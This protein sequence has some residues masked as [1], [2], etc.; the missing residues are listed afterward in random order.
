[1]CVYLPGVL[2]KGSL[3]GALKL[4]L[5]ENFLNQF[6]LITNSFDFLIFNFNLSLILLLEG[7]LFVVPG[8]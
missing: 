4:F 7:Y 5:L 1:M 3:K 8:P 6:D 2:K